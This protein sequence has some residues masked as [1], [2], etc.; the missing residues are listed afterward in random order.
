MINN[1]LAKQEIKGEKSDVNEHNDSWTV[2]YHVRFSGKC[3]P[4]RVINNPHQWIAFTSGR[5]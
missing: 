5:A 1:V 3:E 4:V 2:V